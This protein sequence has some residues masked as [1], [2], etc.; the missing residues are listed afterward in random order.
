MD[1][2]RIAEEEIAE[3]YL[4]DRLEEPLREEFEIH[5]LGCPSC[6]ES[7]ETLQDLREA[8]KSEAH[9]I[10]LAPERQRVQWWTWVLATAATLIV[11]AVGV[12]Q[13]RVP[14]TGEGSANIAQQRVP[15]GVATT[16]V[17][18][19]TGKTE[20]KAARVYS[21]HKGQAVTQS[22]PPESAHLGSGE[23]GSPPSG[24]PVARGLP[25]EPSAMD[26]PPKSM[27]SEK[28]PEVRRDLQKRS[29][30]TSAQAV[31]L[32][33]LAEVRAAPYSFSGLA[34]GAPVRRAGPVEQTTTAGAVAGTTGAVSPAFQRAMVAYVE[35]RYD[36]ASRM[37]ETAAQA[38]PKAPN[39]NFYL[40]VCR[41]LLGRPDDAIPSLM[42]VTEDG[43]SLLVQPAH[44]YLA[45]A[46][47]QKADLKSAESELEAAGSLP[48]PRKNEANSLLLRVRAFRTAIEGSPA[49]SPRK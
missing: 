16:S 48:G 38:D 49:A 21:Q 41:L 46:Y 10:R 47:L 26:T 2:R 22:A 14:K 32:Y 45:K 36:D 31:E 17:G 7:V 6:L 28:Q 39:I 43:K 40:G 20:N 4:S 1:C 8:L 29:E 5:I 11:A 44:V 24:Q 19:E 27:L 12:L 3:C 25:E 23:P 34:Q 42:R 9:Q 30:L 37:L 15:P 18:D 33:R 13:W 35:G